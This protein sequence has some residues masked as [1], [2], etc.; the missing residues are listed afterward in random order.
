MAGDWTMAPAPWKV[1]HAEGRAETEN[2]S[3]VMK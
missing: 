3:S 1:F 2:F